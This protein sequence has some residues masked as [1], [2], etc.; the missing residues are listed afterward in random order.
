MARKRK[1]KKVPLV[2][3]AGSIVRYVGKYSTLS[4]HGH[5]VRIIALS[6]KNRVV[7]EAIG[8]AGRPVRFTVNAS[9]LAVMQPDLF[10][11]LA[12]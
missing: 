4:R 6:L 3:K 9:N 5:N 10:G 7:V 2:I 8:H 1:Q 11:A 12:Q